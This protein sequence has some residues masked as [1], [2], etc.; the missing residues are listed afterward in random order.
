M[1]DVDPHRLPRTARPEHY[2][3]ALAPD[4]GAGTFTGDATIRVRVLTATHSLVCNALDLVVEE[5]WFD[6]GSTRHALEVSHD[7]GTERVTFR[8]PTP[9]TPGVGS[10]HV[11]FR[12]E[13]NDKLRGFYRSRF[14]T[15]DGTEHVLATTQFQATDARRA[16]PCWDEPEYK[17]PFGITLVVPPGLQAVSNSAPVD[18]T[19]LPDGRR[20]IRFADTMAMSTYLVAFVVGPLEF[21]E[22]VDVDGVPLR[23]V[24]TPGQ[25]KLAAFA[26][27]AGAFAL[28][29]FTDYY[30]IPYPGDK[31][32]LV[33]IPDFAFGAME[34]L[35]CVTFRETLLLVDPD[36]VT[37][38]ELQR[39]TDVINHE[40]AHMWF[41]D[42]VTMRWWN[43]IWLNEAFA[44]FMEMKCTDAYRP[45]WKRWTDFGLSRS[46]AMDV[47]SL[48]TTRPIEYEV[49]S[50]ADAEGM[51]DLL[52]YEKGAAVV[53]M[54]EQYLG[55]DRFRDGIRRYLTAHAYGS[56]ETHDL[57]DALE[58]ATGEPV[59]RM[60]DSWIF[61]GGHPVVTVAGSG[62]ATVSQRR[63]RYL[64]DPA[65][66][67][68]VVPRRVRTTE[69]EGRAL[70]DTPAAEATLPAGELRTANV[71]GTGFYRVRLDDAQLARLASAGP[72][73]LSPI[74]RYGLIDD[75]WAMVLAADVRAEQY[76]AV[77]RVF[78]DEDDLS[79][80]Q[81]II[82]SL[83]VLRRVAG[84]A[85]A[86][87]FRAWVLDLLAP[88]RTRLG[89]Q[90]V[91]GEDVRTGQLRG[92]LFSAAGVLGG[93]EDVVARARALA[94]DPTADPA[95]L[96][97]AIDIVAAHG[98]ADEHAR[99]VTSMQ[100]APSPQE[101]ERF[102]GALADFP[103]AAE[104]Q[105]TLTMT[106]DGTL[107]TQDVPF[108]IRRALR[109]IAQGPEA[110][111]FI[112]ERWDDLTAAIPSNLVAR[113]LEG[114][115]ALAEPEQAAAVA[116][117]LD[118]HPVPQGKTLIEQ[119]RERLRVHVALRDRERPRLATVFG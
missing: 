5:A 118:D 106:L 83:D 27:D 104:I 11:Q 67:V 46:A 99:Y 107:R 23:V 37:Q 53:R 13:L 35:G 30:G 51:F 85:Q 60:M 73:G 20:R 18:E 80:W 101:I 25:G 12:G 32:D 19:A 29:Y 114:V 10:L 3:L 66:A 8:S 92:A 57:W 55:E 103:G 2:D 79:V 100:S 47:D 113:M 42:L 71:E 93:A 1:T 117:F 4:L 43:G 50:P 39:V 49:R 17:A 81:R 61:Q 116:S 44:T 119:H 65:Q 22:P 62:A 91:V 97:A 7:A 59:R 105:R 95:L 76:L 21:T 31:V 70:L 54:L 109:N 110:W 64:P 24:H 52:T 74:E 36:A 63:F 77:L 34:N 41:G 96:A 89:D 40:L 6:D 78:R 45:G 98:T 72:V 102:R 58:A 94:V 82:G 38:P 84:P 86:D 33:A 87:A 26:L 108:V 112:T 9:L 28:R 69:A 88:A 90:P 115:S 56:T 14:R 15:S 16:F 111:R 48:A 75:T 68:G